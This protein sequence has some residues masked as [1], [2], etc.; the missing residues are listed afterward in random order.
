MKRE[1][2]NERDAA[3]VDS[4][5]RFDATAERT[6]GLGNDRQAEPRPAR[7]LS[8]AAHESFEDAFSFIR[9]YARTVIGDTQGQLVD[10][11][12]ETDRYPA[13]GIAIAKGIVDEILNDGVKCHAVGR[14]DQRLGRVERQIDLSFNG[15]R[16]YRGEHFLRMKRNIERRSFYL[17]QSIDRRQRQHLFGEV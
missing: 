7:G 10:L 8:L 5:G 14:H 6:C 4:I 9:R 12:S 16:Y 15:R 17:A 11:R 2:D 3:P 13:A 1:R